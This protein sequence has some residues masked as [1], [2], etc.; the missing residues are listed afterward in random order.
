MKEGGFVEL[1]RSL[2]ENHS[3]QRLD[4][5]KNSLSQNT[6]AEFFQALQDNFVL[7]ELR[8]DVKTKTMPFGAHYQFS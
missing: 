4:L 2:R 8:I 6:L 5:S 7:C 1:A 3:L